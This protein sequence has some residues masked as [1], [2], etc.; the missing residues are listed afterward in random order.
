MNLREFSE[1]NF[2]RYVKTGGQEKNYSLSFWSNALCGE[3]GELA[4][5][6]KKID[7]GDF[8]VDDIKHEL[9]HEIGD[10]LTYLDLLS[11]ILGINTTDA[12]IEKWNIVSERYD[13][14]VRCM[15]GL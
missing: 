13:Y 12:L 11:S 9:A 3:A 2:E 14:P 6:I 7:R 1:H 15:T 4:N 5:L 10:V 8:T